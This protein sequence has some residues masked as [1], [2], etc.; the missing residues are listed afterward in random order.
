MQTEIDEKLTHWMQDFLSGEHTKLQLSLRQGLAIKEYEI[1][2]RTRQALGK[3]V[4]ILDT[5]NG[6]YD[7]YCADESVGQCLELIQKRY[8]NTWKD[9]PLKECLLKLM[10][11]VGFLAV[12]IGLPGEA[13]S[14]FDLLA[15]LEPDD[16]H[17]LLGFAYTKLAAGSAEEAL[18]VI[19]D[20]VLNL[21]PG[22]HLGLAFLALAYHQLNRTEEAL[23]AAS[24]VITVS[25]DED[26]VTLALE[27]QRSLGQ[28]SG[29][30]NL[31]VA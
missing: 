18:E 4:A 25:H 15:L 12:D 31:S 17:P 8:E 6:G 3:A 10:I 28:P 27:I 13:E 23:A 20:K 14:L 2:D 16:I 26:A 22:N 24:A 7:T 9:L 30:K 5:F 29:S 1:Q 21:A 11:G 19:H